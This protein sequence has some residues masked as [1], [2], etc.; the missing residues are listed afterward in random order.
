MRRS[1]YLGV[2]VIVLL[3][4]IGIYLAPLDPCILHL[5][6]AFSEESFSTVLSKWQS[7]GLAL[8]QSHIPADFLLLVTYGIFGFQFG[9]ERTSALAAQPMLATCLTWA[10]PLA[11]VADATENVLHLLL[12]GANAPSNSLLYL[13]SGSAASIKWLGIVAFF[14][15][16]A[17]YW[18]RRE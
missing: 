2:L 5:Q 17:L 8:Y 9:R 3:A 11:A 14:A 12:T 18:K 4:G 15:C 10:L 6:F 16:I 1:I 13:L 7:D